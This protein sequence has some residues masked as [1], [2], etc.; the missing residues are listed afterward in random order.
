MSMANYNALSI[1]TYDFS[2]YTGY[3]FYSENVTNTK[4]NNNIP[5]FY[6]QYDVIRGPVAK[7]VDG[8]WVVNT[9]FPYQYAFRTDQ[10]LCSMEIVGLIPV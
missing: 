8:N 3:D 5:E 4:I 2:G 10:S 6:L 1:Y 7:K 9:Q